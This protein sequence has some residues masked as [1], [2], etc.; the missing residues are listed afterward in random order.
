MR[1]SQA[2]VTTDRAS[3]YLAQLSE[4]GQKMNH[5]GLHRFR[6]HGH[7]DDGGPPEVR[8]AERSSDTDGVI[9]FGWGR[10]VLHATDTE[11]LLRAEADE[12]QH[13]RRIEDG[14]AARVQR[15]G[16]RDGLSVTWTRGG[17]ITQ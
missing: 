9:D 2:R 11:L 14:I 10:C 8:H 7:A 15:I 3:R 16:R 6:G 1:T 12:E 13:L 17:G 4:H 5:R